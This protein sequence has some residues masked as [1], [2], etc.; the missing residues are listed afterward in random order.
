MPHAPPNSFLRLLIDILFD[1]YSD[2]LMVYRLISGCRNGDRFSGKFT[3]TAHDTT[4]FCGKCHLH[5]EFYKWDS[6]LIRYGML[7][8]SFC[9]LTFKQTFKMQIFD[10]KTRLQMVSSVTQ[11]TDFIRTSVLSKCH[12]FSWHKFKCNFIYT[13]KKNTNPP[14]LTFMN[15]TKCWTLHAGHTYWISPNSDNR[16][17]K[18]GSKFIYTPM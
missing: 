17:G 4:H 3:I 8:T 1:R 7:L 15:F 13:H 16:Y 10:D 11:Y 9:P 2:I 6:L 5:I 14:A 12:T 18:H